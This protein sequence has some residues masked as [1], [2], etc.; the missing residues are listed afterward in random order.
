MEA[1]NRILAGITAVLDRYN[2]AGH[3]IGPTTDL[4]A[5]VERQIKSRKGS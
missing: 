4:A 1:D 5:L 2:P 3:V